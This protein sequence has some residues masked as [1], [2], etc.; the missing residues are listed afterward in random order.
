MLLTRHRIID[1]VRK[2]RARPEQVLPLPADTTTRGAER[3]IP[4]AA[5]E[6]AFESM[7]DEEWEKNL[8]DVAMERVK[9]AVKP[10]HYQ[11]FYL[12]G[13]RNLPARDVGELMG[14]SSAKVYV[15]RHRVGQLLKRELRALSRTAAG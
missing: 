6:K 13:V 3:P 7:W 1:L 10:E 2:S 8:M 9:R 15:V 12:H 14:I 4:D 5:A 11:I